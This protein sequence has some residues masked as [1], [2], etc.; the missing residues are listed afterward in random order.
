M[1]STVDTI[2]G[3]NIQIASA[4]NEQVSVSEEINRNVVNINNVVMTTVDACNQ[5]TQA[6]EEVKQLAK[7]ILD[8][9]SQFKVKS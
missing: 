5:T 3:M 6:S 4:A 8:Q 9:M 7:A 1:N 2:N